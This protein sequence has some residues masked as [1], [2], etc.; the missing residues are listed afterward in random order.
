MTTTWT[1][2][3][4]TSYLSLFSRKLLVIYHLV[5]PTVSASKRTPLTVFHRTL[6][7]DFVLFFKRRISPILC[8]LFLP[9]S[10]EQNSTERDKL[11]PS[12]PT[13]S[14]RAKIM[15]EVNYEGGDDT[16]DNDGDMGDVM[17]DNDGHNKAI[18][19]ANDKRD[20][21]MLCHHY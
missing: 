7:G 16:V 4:G 2:S 9:C 20:T 1:W 12:G 5:D 14:Y 17:V 3:P 6:Y 8:S 15:R 10:W 18:D 13:S 21:D 11:C 19:T